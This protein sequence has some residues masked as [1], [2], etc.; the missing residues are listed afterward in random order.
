MDRRK[1]KRKLENI[2]INDKITNRPYQKEANLAV[3]DAITKKH[4]KML[5]VQAQ[6]MEKRELALA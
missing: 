4:R 2:E 5:I 1:A 6:E 3:C